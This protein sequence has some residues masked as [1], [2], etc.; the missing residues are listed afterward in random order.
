MTLLGLN[1]SVIKITLALALAVGT[2]HAMA[3][4]PGPAKSEQGKPSV[5]KGPKVRDSG[6][7][8]E[9]H[10]F[11]GGGDGK[12]DRESII[13]HRM[14]LHAFDVLR[15]DQ[16]GALALT[17]DQ[18]SQLKSIEESFRTTMDAYRAEHREEA[19]KLIADLPPQERRRAMELLGPGGPGGPGAADRAPGQ[20]PE[21]G[22]DKAPGKG[23]GKG[24]GKGQPPAPP[25]GRPMDDGP[26]ND[27]GGPVDP[28]KAEAAKARLKELFE[29]APKP[30]D[31][32]SK[33]FAVL[34]ADQKAAVETELERAKKEMQDRRQ[35][36]FKDRVKKDIKGKIDE[37]GKAGFDP[38]KVREFVQNLPPEER[39]K[40]RDMEPKERREYIRKLWESRQGK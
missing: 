3:Y 19:R 27:A 34:T 33:M 7:P 17:A 13:P 32:H 12:F 6:V 18:E 14:F 16:A 23:K 26:M 9:N 11:G 21:R 8:G 24:K 29:G 38:E 5:L 1:R 35:E 10:M 31:V 40:I 39:Q 20:R 28:Q 22:I 37:A 4:Q 25:E 30:D 15:G 36:M 2:S